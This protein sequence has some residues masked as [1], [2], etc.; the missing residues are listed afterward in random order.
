MAE[1]PIEVLFAFIVGD[2]IVGALVFGVLFPMAINFG[3]YA[4]LFQ[5]MLILLYISMIV[6][7]IKVI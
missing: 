5:M 3:V 4:G 7:E 2:A 1:S 6:S